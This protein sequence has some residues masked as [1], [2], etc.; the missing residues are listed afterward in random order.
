MFGFFKKKSATNAETATAKDVEQIPS[1]NSVEVLLSKDIEPIPPVIECD[2]KNSSAVNEEL[3]KFEFTLDDVRLLAEVNWKSNESA[4]IHYAQCG[5]F[6]HDAYFGDFEEFHRIIYHCDPDAFTDKD[7]IKASEKFFI[8]NFRRTS[9]GFGSENV[10][11]A[12]LCAAI[13]SGLLKSSSL[14]NIKIE[15]AAELL[16]G[17]AKQKRDK[18]WNMLISYIDDKFDYLAPIFRRLQGTALTK[19]GEY[20]PTA[21]LQEIDEFI[22]TFFKKD[23]FDFYHVT[24]P[25]VEL[26]NYIERRLEILNASSTIDMPEDGVE[27]EYWCANELTKQGWV[28]QVSKASGDQ[29][30]DI[31][32]NRDGLSVAVQ[33]KRYGQPIGNKAVQEIF[34]AKQFVGSKYACVIGT[35][36]F[37]RSARELAGAT[38]VVLLEAE[39]GLQ[40]FSS[41]FGFDASRNTNQP[42]DA[43]EDDDHAFEFNFDADNEAKKA[44]IKSFFS[45]ISS[46]KHSLEDEDMP[47]IPEALMDNFDPD[48]G[49]GSAKLDAATL[50]TLLIFS[51]LHLSGEADMTDDIREQFRSSDTLWQ[52]KIGEDKSIQE[53]SGIL[54]YASTTPEE[55]KEEFRS[56]WN[57]CETFV[58]FESEDPYRQALNEI[59]RARMEGN[60]PKILDVVF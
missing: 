3:L 18:D 60:R 58:G 23:D 41:L 6:K 28:T 4:I 7:K 17:L 1:V 32:A 15:E 2:L 19:Y 22:D 54:G 56:F 38:G 52:Q 21:E 10:R 43:D 31:I 48:T 39:A 8:S 16:F 24:K 46:M 49:E 47:E 59:H 42:L 12:E 14:Q 44:I 34:T 11:I 27:F 20:D 45:I 37:T 5:G 26:L 40:N 36:G 35:G 51:D 25:T 13:K 9:N 50:C 29:G 55:I 53:I 57:L 30:I 33:C